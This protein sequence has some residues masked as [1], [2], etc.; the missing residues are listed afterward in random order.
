MEVGNQIGKYVSSC[1]NNFKGV[2]R[3]YMRTRVTMDITKPL[4][5]RMKVRRAG[6]EWSWITFKSE[7]VPTFCFICGVLGHSD[8]FCSKLFETPES[9][10]TR[11]FGVWMRAPLRQKPQLIGSKW[12]R[13]GTENMVA[14]EASTGGG[15]TES[16]QTKRF[17]PEFTERN[18][19][20][21]KKG[22]MLKQ[23]QEVEDKSGNSKIEEMMEGGRVHT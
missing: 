4:K 1:P 15:S 3:E 2:W 8:K 19:F 21:P 20:I 16:A 10:I 7:N 17:T 6:N 9:E 13:N 18:H 23:N 14:G 5:R 22:D 11:P 12:L